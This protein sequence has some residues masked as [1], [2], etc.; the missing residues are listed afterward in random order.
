MLKI[1]LHSE[2][3]VRLRIFSKNFKI[4]PEAP[5]SVLEKKLTGVLGLIFGSKIF[6]FLFLG[7]GGGGVAKTLLLFWV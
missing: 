1:I 5:G 7:G 3:I 6:D 2:G 4:I